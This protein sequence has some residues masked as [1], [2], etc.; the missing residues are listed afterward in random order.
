[1]SDFQEPTEYTK[2]P[3][4]SEQELQQKVEGMREGIT[5]KLTKWADR[6][7]VSMAFTPKVERL[8]GERW[9]EGGKTWEMKGG[10]PQSVSMLQAARMPHWCP[11][12]SK[13]LNHRFDRKFYYLRGW[14]YNCN[15]D[16]EG[17][18]RLKNDGSWERYE[19]RLMRENEKSFLRD[20]INKKLD[21]MR[22]FKEPELVF[23]DG[24]WEKLA[25]IADFKDMFE[26][27]EKDIEFMMTRLEQI[28]KEEQENADI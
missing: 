19:K 4:L 25:T 23:G 15:I 16:I 20:E 5:K 12:C 21:Y 7:Q 24:R 26:L 9:E 13:P 18:M 1:M 10:I 11:K 27:L 22:T 14:C 2:G 3:K 28:N 8:E 6:I 17:A